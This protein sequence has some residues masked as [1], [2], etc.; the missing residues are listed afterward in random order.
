M[1]VVKRDGRSE[2]VKFDKITARI[3][4][5]AY[6]LNSEF[7]DP[8]QVAQKVTA[9]V[10]KG[11]KTSELDE[12]ASETA[13]SMATQHPDYSTLAARIAVSNLHKNTEKVFTNVVEKMHKHVNPKNNPC[14]AHRRRR[15]RHHHG[16]RREAQQ[17]DHLRQGL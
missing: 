2:E 4:K 10:Y 11:V 5:L 14:S 3:G 7:C 13:A 17:R 16:K 12:L 15:L 9:G 1:F 8:T 6:G